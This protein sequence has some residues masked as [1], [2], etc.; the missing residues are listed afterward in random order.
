[1]LYYWLLLRSGL[2]EAQRAV[3]IPVVGPLQAAAAAAA[4]RDYV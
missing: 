4:G 2:P 3:N 1:M